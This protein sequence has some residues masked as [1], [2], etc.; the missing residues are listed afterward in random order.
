[1]KQHDKCT[2]DEMGG[3]GEE[4]GRHLQRIKGQYRPLTAPGALSME[5]SKLSDEP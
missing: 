4:G 3:S 1:M 2:N 5:S